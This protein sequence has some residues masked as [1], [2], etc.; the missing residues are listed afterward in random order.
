ML[1]INLNAN[2]TKVIKPAD[3]IIKA[4]T[5][6]PD[7]ITTQERLNNHMVETALEHGNAAVA[8]TMFSLQQ[9]SRPREKNYKPNIQKDM[10]ERDLRQGNIGDSIHTAMREIL[11]GMRE[12][13]D[14]RPIFTSWAFEDDPDYDVNAPEVKALFMEVGSE[15]ASDMNEA[16]SMEELI[17]TRDQILAAKHDIQYMDENKNDFIIFAVIIF[18]FILVY[19]FIKKSKKSNDNFIEINTNIKENI[20]KKDIEQSVANSIKK[21]SNDE[22]QELINKSIAKGDSET[23]QTL[24]KV[25]ENLKKL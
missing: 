23:A 19:I 25:L 18:M 12:L 8:N 9:A 10:M 2:S 17:N 21:N 3:D 20:E 4:D 11:P 14:G 22:I 1:S 13:E 6:K 5:S 16:K 7:F 24:L 15:Y